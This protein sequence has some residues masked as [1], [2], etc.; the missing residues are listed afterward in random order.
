MN[1]ASSDRVL[2]V[3]DDPNILASYARTLRRNFAV[4]T[5]LGAPLALEMVEK[6]EPYAVIVSDMRMPGMDGIQLL[7][8]VRRLAPFSVRMMLTG[9]ADQQTAIDAVNEGNIFRFMTKPCPPER[10]ART[11]RAGCRQYRL[12]TAE[13]ELL[14]QTLR[15]SVDV[16]IEVLS[17]V[18]PAA[19]GRAQRLK[20][21]VHYMTSALKREDAWQYELAALLSQLGCVSLPPDLIKKVNA[22]EP[23]SQLENDLLL[24]HPAVG[25]RLIEK[26]PRLETVARIVADQ[27]RAYSTF[28]QNRTADEPDMVAL[29]AQM[30]HV[31]VEYDL[32]TSRDQ[33]CNEAL[34]AMHAHAGEYNPRLLA[35]LEPLGG[36]MG[37]VEIRAVR[38]A[39]LDCSMIVHEDI[40]AKNGMTL[41]AKGQ[42]I[43]LPVLERLR[44]FHQGM[45]VIEPVLVAVPRA[46][47]PE[48]RPEDG[49]QPTTP[50]A[51]HDA[52]ADTARQVQAGVEDADSRILA[53]LSG[54]SAGVRNSE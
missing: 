10:L 51:D 2:L 45:G 31:A 41:V 14:E 1:P 12:V 19:F 24:A 26:I 52:G 53:S 28:L 35:L 20:R 33:S 5:A 38:L 3:D 46:S 42:V 50:E 4:E 36:M 13:R 22:G 9:N 48:S 40:L 34:T 8:H 18:S 54:W 30:L 17:V 16:L 29:C 21:Y 44:G 32:R 25:G 15:G 39:E 37:N 7:A 43:S 11:L 27:G 49:L 23:L 47:I 6:G